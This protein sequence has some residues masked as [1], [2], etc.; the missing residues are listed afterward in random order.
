MNIKQLKTKAS[1]GVVLAVLASP[2]L[3]VVPASAATVTWRGYTDNLLGNSSNWDVSIPVNGD[4]VEFLASPSAVRTITNDIS[5]LSLAKIVF[6]NQVDGATSSTSYTISGNPLTITG[7]IDAIMGGAAGDQSVELDIT[8]GAD[9]TFKTSG[10]NTLQVGDTATTLNLAA[11]DLTLDASGGT[12]SILGKIT[13]SGTIT[14]SGTGKVLLL[15]TP[16]T[17]GFTGS[18]AVPTGELAVNDNLG[19]NVTVSGGTLKGTGTVGT[20]TMSSGT[21]APGASPG[22]LN[23]GALTFTGGT[24]AVELGGKAAGEFDKLNVTGAVDLGTATTLDVQLVNSFKPAVNDSFVIIENDAD[25]E[26]E[27]NFKDLEDGDTFTLGTYTYQINYDGGTGN[28]VVL[29]VTGTSAASAPD[30]GGGILTNPITTIVAAFSIAA[31]LA[32][33]RVYEAKKLR[34]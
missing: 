28:D 24:H 32:G 22:T 6:K 21:V 23:T 33:Y 34:K 11:N 14:K 19:V 30:T 7:G 15:T 25:D 1:I 8:L 31:M 16:G 20:V 3:S 10:S 27:G 29:L 26:V 18:M 9:A 12:I 13:G 17:G 2:M 5:S 4:T